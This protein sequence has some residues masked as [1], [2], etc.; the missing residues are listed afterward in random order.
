MRFWK[1]CPVCRGPLPWLKTFFRPAWARW[2]CTDCGSIIGIDTRRR[3]LAICVWTAV[4]LGWM[5]WMRNAAIPMPVVFAGLL[6]LCFITITLIDR[7]VPIEIR[8]VR[9]TGCGYDLR[10]ASDD[11][12]PEC[13]TVIED[14]ILA[15][16]QTGE[17]GHPLTVPHAM[18]QR[19][20]LI[21]LI[22]FVSV[23]LLAAGL[24]LGIR[25]GVF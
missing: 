2:E 18:R 20:L 15:R 21:L 6:V 8:G 5:F 17:H 13:G 23:A 10:E 16:I 11:A 24:M 7:I 1:V 22:L 3:V 4:L 19:W 9:C 12:C 25:H 14:Y